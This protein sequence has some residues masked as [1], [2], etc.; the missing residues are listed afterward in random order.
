VIVGTLSQFEVDTPRKFQIDGEDVLVVRV[1]DEIFAVSDTCTH[2]EVSLSE[3]D[4]YDGKVECWMHGAAFDLRTGQAL[5]PP[6]TQAL[7]TYLV[8]LG[9]QPDPDVIVTAQQ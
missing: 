3:G 6:A 2:S 4:I 8:A 7:E 1:G 5:T 9:D